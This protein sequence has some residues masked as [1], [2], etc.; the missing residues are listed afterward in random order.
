MVEHFPNL[1]QSPGSN[2]C[3]PTCARAVLLWYGE[4]V[5]QD[6]VSEWCQETSEGCILDLALASLRDEGFDLEEL[7]G[8]A[9]EE[10]EQQ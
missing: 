3:F 7:T 10:A 2:A 8:R 1:R 9:R 6:D 5:T 4:Q